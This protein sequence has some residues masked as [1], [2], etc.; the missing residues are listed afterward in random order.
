[1]A[2]WGTHQEA[3]GDSRKR[4]RIEDRRVERKAQNKSGGGSEGDEPPD[5]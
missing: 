2:Y 3:K 1:M 4:R 5:A